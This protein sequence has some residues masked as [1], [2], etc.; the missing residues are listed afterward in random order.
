VGATAHSTIQLRGSL[1]IDCRRD[2]RRAV[3]D[4]PVRGAIVEL[5]TSSGQ[6][7]T[8][9]T[10]RR[11]RFVFTVRRG[12]PDAV[13]VPLIQTPLDGLVPSPLSNSHAGTG[14]SI[15][16]RVADLDRATVSAARPD[17]TAPG[18]D[19]GFIAATAGGRALVRAECRAPPVRRGG[20]AA[21]ELLRR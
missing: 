12:R 10:N 16:R 19:F 1:W 4:P 17:G 20:R 11:G 8:T 9:V 5:V 14:R 2:G 15:G 18:Y 7:S 3:Q 21:A 13:E 6:L